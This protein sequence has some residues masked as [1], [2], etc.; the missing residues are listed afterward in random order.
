M[1][2]LAADENFNN[3]ILNGLLLRS[4]ALDIVRVQDTPL[5]GA[6]DPVVLEWAAKQGRILLT[7]DV[8]TMPRYAYQRVATGDPMPG[9]VAVGSLVPVARAIEDLLI[10]TECSREGEWEGRVIFLPF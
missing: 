1:I 6:V 9:V 2:E 3:D 7:H 10:L 8:K 5:F 4:P